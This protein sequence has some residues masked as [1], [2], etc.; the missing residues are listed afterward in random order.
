[1]K[2]RTTVNTGTSIYLIANPYDRF[3]LSLSLC[4]ALFYSLI[5]NWRGYNTNTGD[6][7]GERRE[8][9]SAFNHEASDRLL[10][11]RWK[12]NFE[13]LWCQDM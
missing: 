7:S 6:I 4:E 8:P 11:W 1:M 12:Y 10:S 13:C 2:A 9:V 5:I 3:I